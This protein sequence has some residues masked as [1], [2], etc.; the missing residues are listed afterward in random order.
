MHKT[1]LFGLLL[2]FTAPAA[3]AELPAAACTLLQSCRM[4]GEGQLRWWGFHVYDASLWS[5]SGRWQAQAP[6]ALDIRYARRVTGAQ[7]AETSVDELR[8]L[9]I[10]DEAA[11]TRWGAA[12]R[13]LFPDVAPGSRLIGVHVPQRGALF[14]SATGYLGAI[15]DPEFARGFFSIW[16]DPRTQTPELRAAL[17]GRDARPE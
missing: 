3:V 12:M 4:V 6:Y 7:L 17:L 9:G 2:L 5:P 15:E 1:I 14:Y 10:G 8:R 16:L 13:K 11:L